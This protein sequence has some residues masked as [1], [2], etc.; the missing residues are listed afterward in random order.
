[1]HHTERQLLA[2]LA[3]ESLNAE[4]AYRIDHDLS[5][6]VADLF[7][8]DGTYGIAGAGV[9]AG[10]EAIRE[11]YRLRKARGPRTARHIFTNLRLEFDS[12][13]QARGTTIML[14]FA[15]DG[16]PPHPAEPLEVSDF[17][18]VYVRGADGAW[19][20]QSRTATIFFKH[21]SGKGGVLPLGAAKAA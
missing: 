6:T 20:Y 13:T 10:R 2:R 9:S 3:I 1:M 16:A 7:V 18:D 11:A 19:R 8:E 12:E 4:F 21:R 15:E 14:L 17:V 5:D